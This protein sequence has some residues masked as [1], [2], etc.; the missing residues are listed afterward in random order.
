MTR[1]DRA[2]DAGTDT[3]ADAGDG[4]GAEIAGM[5]VR[6]R[7]GDEGAIGEIVERC[8]P[9]L[10]AVAR[11]CVARASDVDD[12]VQDVWLTFVQNLD[13]IREPAATRGWLVR[14]VTHTAWRA[15]QR[16]GRC[17]PTADLDAGASDGDTE[18]AALRQVWCEDL[19]RRLA[20]ALGAL[21][22]EDRRLVV[23]LAS[24]GQPDYRTVG[25]VVGRPIGSIG[26]TRQRALERL[27]RQ[28]SLVAVHPAA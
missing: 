15:Q 9:M 5:V 7:A 3:D 25:E 26:P 12:V 28:P 16:A 10:R 24:D 11:R 14:V 20:P 21:R 2:D 17:V 4:D 27:R 1:R 18:D 22:A 8:T 6:A 19:R 13:R 23:L